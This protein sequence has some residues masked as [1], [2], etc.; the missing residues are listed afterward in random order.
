MTVTG[1]AHAVGA[2][3]EATLSEELRR[4]GSHFT[5]PQLAVDLTNLVLNRWAPAVRHGPPLVVDP[6]C[7]AGV[8]LIT[9]LD[10][11]VDGGMA[12]D[13][14][15][16]CVRGS[17]VDVGAVHAA[18]AALV[19]WFDERAARHSF[20]HPL[21]RRS[22]LALIDANVTLG[23]GF[24]LLEQL[25]ANVDIVIGNPPFQ[26]QL[27]TSTARSSE[28]R[29]VAYERFGD[30]AKGYV[31]TAALFLLA[32]VDSVA[33]GGSV[34]M[35]Q[36]R[37]TLAAAHARRIR[38]QVL[39]DCELTDLWVDRRD[40]FGA[41]VAVCATLLS[42]RRSGP[43]TRRHATPVSS[44]TLHPGVVDIGSTMTCPAPT[45]FDDSWSSC[46]ASSYR[47][48][49]VFIGSG[50][51]VGEV[52]TVTSGFRDQYYG[53][54]GH[55]EETRPT[56]P[57]ARLITSG[58]INVGG[59][60]WGDVSQRFA[61]AR[62][63]TPWVD[64]DAVKLASTSL[65]S[66]L[67]VMARPKVLV[68][69]QTRV[70]EAM[71]DPE[72]DYLGATPVIAVA[73]S[74]IGMVVPLAAALSAPPVAAW[75]AHRCAGSGMSRTSYRFRATDLA[76]VRLPTGTAEWVAATAA[77]E[78]GDWPLFAE[79]SCAAYGLTAQPATQLVTWWLDEIPG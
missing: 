62:W 17:D 19:C 14:A 40:V 13:E 29:N 49:R 21:D 20:G 56:G 35:I 4:S 72:G 58:A 23:D 39:Q 67:G 3:Y 32:A 68:A 10:A 5:P 77:F 71:A 8:F 42:K 30:A 70:V 55:I 9:A 2:R 28:S 79:R 43:P 12:P 31:D 11:L 74:D 24:D 44:T 61:K 60:S 18:R 64:L 48:P 66:W 41:S 75:L 63:Q 50:P 1:Q 52:A 37:S 59:H 73:P 46:L 45:E 69:T 38:Q 27:H 22:I 76:A 16:A 15:I 51:A 26:S 36:P 53:L 25:A 6:T 65:R 33:P 34:L 57:S 47:V 7:G 78:L 54:V